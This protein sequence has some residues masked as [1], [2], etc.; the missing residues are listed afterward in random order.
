MESARMPFGI[1]LIVIDLIIKDKVYVLINDWG[2]MAIDIVIKCW[3]SLFDVVF[4]IHA[5]YE[6]FGNRI[7]PAIIKLIYWQNIRINFFLRWV[8]ITY[9]STWIS[10]LIYHRSF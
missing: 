1:W 8:F 2:I 10:I 6:T 4:L 7:Q 5:L 3:L 9:W